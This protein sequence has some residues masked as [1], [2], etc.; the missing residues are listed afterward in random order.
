MTCGPHM[1][2]TEAS[3]A[4]IVVLP[5]DTATSRGE[6]PSQIMWPCDLG[7]REGLLELPLGVRGTGVGGRGRRKKE[8]KCGSCTPKERRPLQASWSCGRNP[9]PHAGLPSFSAAAPADATGHH[10]CHVCLFGFSPTFISCLFL[11]GFKAGFNQEICMP[12]SF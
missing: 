10:D 11:K 3:Q 4:Q 5:G 2:L 8:S 12:S 6:T 7:T 1:A 9:A